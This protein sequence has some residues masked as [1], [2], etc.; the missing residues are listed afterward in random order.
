METDRDA[1]FPKEAIENL[2][3]NNLMGIPFDK[4]FGGASMMERKIH[5]MKSFMPLWKQ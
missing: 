1:A 3:K 5:L 2:A 4:K